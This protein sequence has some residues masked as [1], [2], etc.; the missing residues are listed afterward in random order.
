MF[1]FQV[2]HNIALEGRPGCT[3]NI[4]AH[5]APEDCLSPRLPRPLARV[6]S[7]TSERLLIATQAQWV[8]HLS[9]SRLR[10]SRVVDIGREVSN[11]FDDPEFESNLAAILRGHGL[12]P[13]LVAGLRMY[14]ALGKLLRKGVV[15]YLLILAERSRFLSVEEIA[16]NNRD[17][18]D[19]A[20]ASAMVSSRGL[21]E[22]L[23]AAGPEQR[24][25]RL[26]HLLKEQVARALGLPEDELDVR[27]PLSQAGLSSLMAAEVQAYVETQLGLELPVAV[28]LDGPSIQRLAE[29]LSDALTAASLRPEPKRDESH[30]VEQ[31]D[32]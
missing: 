5:L 11:F 15:R 31:L 28:L 21:R 3:A 7:A 25:Q 12:D 9:G 2:V 10:I 4:A 32:L 22:T 13:M 30:E 23:L 29:R 26:Q 19:A 1:G 24:R 20:P 17:R 16:K 6:R 8:D 18:L 14:D 27:L